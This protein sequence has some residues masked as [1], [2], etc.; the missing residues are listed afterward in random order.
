M[1]TIVIINYKN[2]F[3]PGEIELQQLHHLPKHHVPVTAA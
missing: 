1:S 3:L 2:R